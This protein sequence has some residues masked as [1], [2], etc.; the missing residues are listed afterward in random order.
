MPRRFRGAPQ[1]RFGFR[2]H[3]EPR[4]IGILAQPRLP[5]EQPPGPIV[6]AGAQL[7][8]GPREHEGRL[9]VQLARRGGEQ[10]FG[11]VPRTPGESQRLGPLRRGL[12][13]VVLG[14]DGERRRGPEGEEGRDALHC[15]RRTRARTR[16]YSARDIGVRRKRPNPV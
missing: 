13:I 5:G 9:E 4:A 10:R 6:A 14:C 1:P 11:R 7:G 12:V 2:Q 16:W 8:L 15:P 3:R